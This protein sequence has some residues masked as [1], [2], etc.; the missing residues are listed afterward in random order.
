MTATPSTSPNRFLSS[1]VTRFLTFL[2]IGSLSRRMAVG[3]RQSRHHLPTGLLRTSHCTFNCTAGV[4]V[5]FTT[6]F[7][8]YWPLLVAGF[9]LRTWAIIALMFSES[10]D[11]SKLTLP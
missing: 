5:A 7:L 10:F 9:I 2:L 6:T 8:K 4:I 11:L 1:L 3:G